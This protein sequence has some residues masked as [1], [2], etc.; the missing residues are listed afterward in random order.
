MKH[1]I[2]RGMHRSIPPM[3]KLV[4][5]GQ[6]NLSAEV[7]FSHHVKSM[8]DV[9]GDT[10]KLFG[11]SFN[12][13]PFR[14][15]DG[16]LDFV[17]HHLSSARFGWRMD[18]EFPGKIEIKSYNYIDNTHRSIGIVGFIEPE[19]KYLMTMIIN[20]DQS[21]IYVDYRMN[22]LHASSFM[23]NY[24]GEETDMPSDSAVINNQNAPLWYLL[25][26]YHG[27]DTVS[28]RYFNINIRKY[29]VR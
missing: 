29:I 7:S 3:I 27:G 25:G 12:C 24:E 9:T 21:N 4:K 18:N 19:E 13:W 17:P 26:P 16:K 10:H 14:N 20:I 11:I 22:K 15:K 23:L 5:P 28:D 6:L 2:L 8:K 1:H